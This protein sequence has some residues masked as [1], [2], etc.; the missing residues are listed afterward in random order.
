MKPNVSLLIAVLL[1]P[2]HALAPGNGSSNRV[3]H[4]NSP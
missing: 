4:A 3:F 1:N 2:L